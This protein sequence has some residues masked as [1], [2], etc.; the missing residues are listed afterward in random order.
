[1]RNEKFPFASIATHYILSHHHR[2][3]TFL[4][5][6]E[7]SLAR[8]LSLT[9]LRGYK[10]LLGSGGLLCYCITVTGVEGGL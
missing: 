6:A 5:E 7:N 10:G 4:W 9:L 2:R 1:M 8:S 3:G